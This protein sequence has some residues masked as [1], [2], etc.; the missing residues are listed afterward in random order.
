MTN[1]VL[2]LLFI[3]L[4][5]AGLILS[6]SKV[7]QPAGPLPS[8]GRVKVIKAARLIL[9]Y[10]HRA[11]VIRLGVKALFLVIGATV[12]FALP[13]NPWWLAIACVVALD[14][15]TILDWW[16]TRAVERELGG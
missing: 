14:I 8:D 2:I 15:E 12:Y 6:G 11:A 16:T 13:I 4:S 10:R 7:L 9:R 5:A 1:D 3:V